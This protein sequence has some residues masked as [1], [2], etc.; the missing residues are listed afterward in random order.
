MNPLKLS[1]SRQK[2]IL[3]NV[4]RDLIGVIDTLWGAVCLTILIASLIGWHR[5][6][7]SLKTVA[8]TFAFPFINIM[9]S[10]YSLSKIPEEKRLR[11][12][13]IRTF[14]INGL[15]LCPFACFQ[16]DGLLRPWWII[17]PMLTMGGMTIFGLGLSSE[18]RAFA[19]V[20]FW[21]V[22]LAVVGV[23]SLHHTNYYQLLQY[24]L[25]V[26]ACGTLVLKLIGLLSRLAFQEYESAQALKTAQAQ[27]IQASRHTALGEMA[28]GVAHEIGNPLAAILLR[29]GQLKR[30][31]AGGAI[32]PDEAGPMFEAIEASANSISGI[33]QGLKI[34]SRDAEG[35]P[36]EIV[37][38]SSVL[39][40]TLAL[41]AA[42][43][44]SKKIDLRV[45]PPSQNLDDL[46]ISARPIQI[47]QTILSLLNNSMTALDHSIERWVQIDVTSTPGSI[48]IAITDNGPPISLDNRTQMFQPFFTTKPYGQGPGLGLSTG[49]GIIEKHGGSL[50]FDETSAKTRFVIQLP[51]VVKPG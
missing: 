42:R 38:V 24:V 11:F 33:I 47:S 35:D 30:L 34:Y 12:E 9:L 10:R 50:T 18:R 51:R 37:S 26:F 39:N 21:G 43:F 1:D 4:Y 36:F 6:D 44:R 17:Y 28:G 2:L 32:R 23:A 16:V 29:A 20:A 7:N 46:L 5:G 25:V 31:T 45:P 27:L 40:D 14:I 48:M 8:I 22:N 3:I 41:C 15:I 13:F 49:K 19:S